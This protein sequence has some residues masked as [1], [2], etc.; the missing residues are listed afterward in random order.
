MNKINSFLT[1]T[2]DKHLL[3]QAN[4]VKNKFQRDFRLYAKFKAVE[5]NT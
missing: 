2:F 3:L 4:F 5:G 1:N